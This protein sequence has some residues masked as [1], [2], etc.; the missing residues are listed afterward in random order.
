MLTGSSACADWIE[1]LLVSLSRC[2]SVLG[3]TVANVGAYGFTHSPQ[4]DLW[5]NVLAGNF[6][7]S[8]FVLKSG[9]AGID[10]V[11]VQCYDFC[12]R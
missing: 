10:S 3:S 9:N 5:V 6:T 2:F 1:Q 8:R 12:S 4:I 7:D 11:R